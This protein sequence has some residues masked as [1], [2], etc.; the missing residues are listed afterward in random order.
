MP[1]IREVVM[2]D[3]DS[4]AKLQSLHTNGVP[5]SLHLERHRKPSK[6]PMLE[7]KFPKIYPLWQ[8]LTVASSS[9]G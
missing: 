9:M 1:L 8:T 7:T 3:L 5:E 4:L 6:I 2:L